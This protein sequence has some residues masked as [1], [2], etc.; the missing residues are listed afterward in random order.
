MQSSIQLRGLTLTGPQEFSTLATLL[1]MMDVLSQQVG[2]VEELFSLDETW[3]LADEFLSIV[4]PESTEARQLFTLF[5]EAW[6][7]RHKILSL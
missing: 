4:S 6:V 3:L 7:I 1:R 2:T 5:L